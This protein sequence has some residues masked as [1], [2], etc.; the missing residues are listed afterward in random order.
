MLRLS[1]VLLLLVNCSNASLAICEGSADALKSLLSLNVVSVFN[2][3]QPCCLI[4]KQFICSINGAVYS[5]TTMKATTVREGSE[6][7]SESGCSG[8][9]L[10]CSYKVT[11]NM[12]LNV[13]HGWVEAFPKMKNRGT[14]W[15][16]NME[17]KQA[18]GLFA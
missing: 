7:E 2:I 15:N 8:C 16:I 3:V 17:E 4:A 13:E 5:T 10:C 12:C 18:I 14:V 6:D 1:T 11:L 9:S